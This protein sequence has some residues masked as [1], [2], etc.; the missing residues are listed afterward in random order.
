MWW[1]MHV[2]HYKRQPKIVCFQSIPGTVELWWTI[3][4]KSREEFVWV[5]EGSELNLNNML[6]YNEVSQRTI[7]GNRKA[8]DLDTRIMTESCCS[9]TLCHHSNN[10]TTQ[11][12]KMSWDQ[13]G[14]WMWPL[15]D[16]C[17]IMMA[18]LSISLDL[19]NGL[20][21]SLIWFQA[22]PKQRRLPTVSR[23]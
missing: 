17:F 7:G 13:N 2:L 8:G 9:R 10:K 6:V 14:Q 3:F 19:T 22:T 21:P 16:L 20:F 4:F 1:G 11:I 18:S 12:L 23:H 15:T 5:L